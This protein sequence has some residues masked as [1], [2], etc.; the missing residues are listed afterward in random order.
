MPYLHREE[1]QVVEVQGLPFEVR[2]PS[3]ETVA[4]MLE[5]REMAKANKARFDNAKNLFDALDK[6]G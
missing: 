2:K 4:A 3:R 6:G 1:L 5:A